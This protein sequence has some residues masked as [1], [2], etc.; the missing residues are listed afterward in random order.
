[1]VQSPFTASSEGP[2]SIEILRQRELCR[3][4]RPRDYLPKA[5]KKSLNKDAQATTTTRAIRREM[6]EWVTKVG[7]F[8]KLS[9]EIPILTTTLLDRF[10][11][12]PYAQ[13]HVVTCVASYRLA[14]MACFYL[15]AKVH[16][17]GTTC[18]VSS[19]HMAALSHGVF[20]AE[21]VEAMEWTILTAMEWHTNPPT[22]LD[23]CREFLGL[24]PCSISVSTKEAAHDLCVTQLEYCMLNDYDTF[25]TVEAST[26]AY[27]AT[28][29][30]LQS[31]G[32]DKILLSHIVDIFSYA[33]HTDYENNRD[34]NKNS[35]NCSTAMAAA[36]VQAS[37]LQALATT[38]VGVAT[39]QQQLLSSSSSQQHKRGRAM[40]F[41]PS[42]S[43]SSSVS[44]SSRYLRKCSSSLNGSPCGVLDRTAL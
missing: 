12:T 13:E 4:Y 42:T 28:K 22:C 2:S 17:H 26:I 7:S 34:D 3:C 31:L 21:Q 43:P 19:N 1:M 39:Q 24:L 6:I 44:S 8:L 14:C 30:A 32:M 40:S 15:T 38:I 18:L 29:T 20:T 27:F 11:Q 16:E 23:F 9:Q 10:M 36:A 37:L 41:S 5:T 25:C 35:K 33:T